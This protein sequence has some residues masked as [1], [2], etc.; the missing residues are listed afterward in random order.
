MA[1]VVPARKRRN[2]RGG[3][4]TGGELRRARDSTTSMGFP[5]QD[6]PA[7]REGALLAMRADE[8]S[9]PYSVI[10]ISVWVEG[11][12]GVCIL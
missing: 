3:R 11:R 5:L 10:V 8:A 6:E 2:S 1:W 9:F 7:E 12:K 4:H